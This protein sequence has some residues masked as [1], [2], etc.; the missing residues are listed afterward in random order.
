MTPSRLILRLIVFIMLTG[1]YLSSALGQTWTQIGNLPAP[2]DLRCAYFWDPNHGVVGGVGCIYTYNNGTWV[3]ATYPEPPGTIKSLRLLDGKNL[4]AASGTTCVWISA[5][6]GATWQK[7]STLLPGADD[8]YLDPFNNIQGM[9]ISGT[10]MMR[11]TSFARINAASCVAARDDLPNMVFSDNGGVTWSTSATNLDAT[12]GYCCVADTCNGT[13]YTLSEGVKPLIYASSDGGNT[14]TFVYDFD[15]GTNDIL[16]GAN[17]G[18]LYAQGGAGVFCSVDQGLSWK[19]IGGPGSTLDDRRM[20]AFGLYNRYLVTMIGGAVWLWDGSSKFPQSSVSASATVTTATGCSPIYTTLTIHW[21]G[22]QDSLLVHAYTKDGG[23]IGPQ[24]TTLFVISGD[25]YKILYYTPFTK[26]QESGIF[27]FHDSA[28]ENGECNLPVE[29][30]TSMTF[31]VTPEPPRLSLPDSINAA[32]CQNVK[33]P[34]TI[35]ADAC[36]TIRIDS[37]GFQSTIGSYALGEQLPVEILPGQTD[38]FWI[39]GKDFMQGQYQLF[40]QISGTSYSTGGTYDTT[41]SMKMDFLGNAAHSTITLINA[42]IKSA[43][44][45]TKI[46]FLVKTSVCDTLWIDSLKFLDTT[47]AYSLDSNAPYIVL[48]NSHDTFWVMENQ[49]IPGQYVTYLYVYGH[50]SY[51]G[52]IDTTFEIYYTVVSSSKTPRVIVH[53]L[54]VSNCKPSVVPIILQALPCDSVEF[55][56]CTI[57]LSSNIKYS[58]DLTIP[59]DL[60]SAALDTILITFPPQGLTGVYVVTAVVKGKYFG[61]QS[62]PFDT[63]VQERVTFTNA[64]SS[65]ISDVGGAVSFTPL[66]LCEETD[67]TVSFTNLGCDTITVTGDQTVW[68][69]GWSATEPS[70]PLLLPPEDS[71]K[72]KINFKPTQVGS[73]SQTVMYGFQY[74]GNK[75]GSIQVVFNGQAIPAVASIAISDTT[76]NFGTFSQCGNPVADTTITITNSGCDSLVLS[77]ASVDAGAGFTLVNGNNMT[78]GPNQ[79][80]LYAIH[81]VDSVPGLFISTFHI[82]GIG[83][84]GGNTIDTMVSLYATITPG[85]RSAAINLTAIDFGATSICKERDSTVTLTNKGCEADTISIANFSSSQFEFPSDISFPIIVLPDSSVTFTIFTHLDTTGH[86]L[87]INGYLNFVL[88]SGVSIPSVTLTR[89]VTY[90]GAFSLSL[91]SEASAPMLAKVPV[92]VL[93]QGTVPM[94]AD[95]IDFDLVYNDNLLSNGIAI[96]PDIKLGTQTRLANGLLDQSIAMQ[97]ATDRDT[98]ATLQFQTYLTKNISTGI[99]LTHQQFLSAGAISPPCV[100]TMDTISIPSNFTLELSCGDSTILAAWNDSPPFS[101]ESIHPNPAQDEITVDISGNAQPEIQMYDALGRSITLPSS[102]N[103]HPSS[104]TV[105]VSSIPTGLYFLRLSQNGFSQSRSIAIQR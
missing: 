56:E 73:P 42:P 37:I 74:E 25:D 68:Q 104:F 65:L 2:S 26:G 3:Q 69:T 22:P 46:P 30:D 88:N 60:P 72:V 33:I 90:P 66:S 102:F 91:A 4:Y 15:G 23:V 32:Y 101:I 100:A 9:N 11:G 95:E 105:D 79:S 34:L 54:S 82:I 24:D 78:L 12:S 40:V 53:N 1:A 93:R 81:F 19:G 77:G 70:F 8:I 35:S 20:F 96:Q 28:W 85:S 67:T 75:S 83:V 98:I 57:T 59:L 50:S 99:Q 21:T 62:T 16:E 84:D 18:V 38:T 92:Y 31:N 29:F 7:T 55:T 27:Y 89:S 17:W 44:T 13:F 47:G 45:I 80:A 103:L 63:T 71:F 94:Q 52:T 5:D 76:L 43:C 39:Y 64:N 58:T 6:R 10:G 14:W 86:P 87:T 97:P 48:P 61:S 36:D 49:T 51:L 41:I